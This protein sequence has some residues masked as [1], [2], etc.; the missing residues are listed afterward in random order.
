MSSI[1]T[2][3]GETSLFAHVF[4]SPFEP[5][6]DTFSPVNSLWPASDNACPHYW[7]GRVPGPVAP[8]AGLSQAQPASDCIC[9]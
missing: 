9:L 1:A 2:T 6:S 3:L 4:P 5:H 7:N 8:H